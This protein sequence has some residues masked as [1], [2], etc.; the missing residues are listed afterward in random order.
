MIIFGGTTEGREIAEYLSDNRIKAYV[1]VASDYGANLLPQSD[2]ITV[3]NDRMD[4][5]K[6]RNFFIG[7]NIHLVIDATHPY[8]TEV[9]G[10]IKEAVDGL[11]IKCLRVVREESQNKNV[12]QFD[13]LTDIISYLRDRDG[14]IFV[15]TGSKELKELTGL[16]GY[17]DR[18]MIRVLDSE[19]IVDMCKKLGF[20]KEYIIAKRGPFSFDENMFHFSIRKNAYLITKDGGSAGGYEDKIKAANRLDM[21]A[22]VIKRPVESGL[23]AKEVMRYI[24][25]L[26]NRD[27]S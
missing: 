19:E 27:R 17:Q 23:T 6:M 21:E 15:T 18:C 25:D 22:L 10:N 2:Y 20:K 24:D 7:K 3:L 8:A 11:D 5:K 1:S 12:K 4:A 14:N 9:T 16:S 13:S 26:Y